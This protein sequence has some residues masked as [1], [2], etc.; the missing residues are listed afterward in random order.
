MGK[1]IENKKII[2]NPGMYW[3]L[4]NLRAEGARAIYSK[5]VATLPAPAVV[6][7]EALLAQ[8]PLI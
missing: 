8:E 2:F 3:L 6:A 1:K 7:S 4:Q 5:P